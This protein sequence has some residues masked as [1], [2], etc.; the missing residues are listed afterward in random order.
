M[1][2]HFVDAAKLI[3]NVLPENAEFSKQVTLKFLKMLKWRRIQ[4]RPSL[5]YSSKVDA[6][7]IGNIINTDFFRLLLEYECEISNDIIHFLAFSP[8]HFLTGE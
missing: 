1:Y 7:F 4:Q 6:I 5:L 2:E 8:P 3:E